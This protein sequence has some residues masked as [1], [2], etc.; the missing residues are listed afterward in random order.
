MN[1]LAYRDQHPELSCMLYVQLMS[2]SGV[3]ECGFPSCSA[4]TVEPPPFPK[5]YFI[6]H[7]RFCW[8]VKIVFILQSIC[9]CVL[10]GFYCHFCLSQCILFLLAFCFIDL[11]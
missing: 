4:W 2:S 8:V 6:F 1:L 7:F 5:V 9:V 11:S 3:V 10:L